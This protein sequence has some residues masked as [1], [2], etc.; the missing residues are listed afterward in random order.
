MTATARG[1]A[2]AMRGGLDRGMLRDAAGY[3]AASL[4]A[5]ACDCG[6]LFLLVHMGASYL[7]AAPV[8]FGAGMVV[9]YLLSVRF[10]FADR[11]HVSREVEILGF[12]AVGLAGLV[13][14][15][16]LLVVLVGWLALSIVLAKLITVACVFLFNFFG[17]RQLV[18]GALA[19]P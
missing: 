18:F 19:R 6:L 15:Q 4:V 17:R 5:L 11:R 10:V 2:A 12:F 16:A 13:L 8:A 14:T 9:A 1:L 7:L 3:G